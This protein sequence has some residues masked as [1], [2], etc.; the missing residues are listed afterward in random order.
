MEWR[1]LDGGWEIALGSA[2]PLNVD[3]IEMAKLT[4]GLVFTGISPRDVAS[5]I[6]EVMTERNG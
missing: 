4:A 3:G 6:S 2:E 1:E 5:I